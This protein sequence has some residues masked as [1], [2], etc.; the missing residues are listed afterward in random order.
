MEYVEPERHT[1]P[2]WIQVTLGAIFAAAVFLGIAVAAGFATGEAGLIVGPVLA[3]ALLVTI[4]LRLRRA[5]STVGWSV[6]IWI[7]TGIGLL[8]NGLCWWS[9]SRMEL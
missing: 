5:P 3:I 7:G 1:L 8:I 6:G 2:K 9:I 4:G